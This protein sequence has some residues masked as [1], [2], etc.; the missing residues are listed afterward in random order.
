MIGL[1]LGGLKENFYTTIL[2]PIS[3]CWGIKKVHE[4]KVSVAEMRMLR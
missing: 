4:N 1:Y 2:R 3:Q